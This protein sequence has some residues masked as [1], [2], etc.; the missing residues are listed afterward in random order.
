MRFRLYQSYVHSQVFERIHRHGRGSEDMCG[1]STDWGL[2][3]MQQE[4]AHR[5]RHHT[6]P[7]HTTPHHTSL[8]TQP[9]PT[10]RNATH[11]HDMRHDVGD[12]RHDI[13]D[14]R[15]VI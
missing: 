7:H 2:L 4:Y 14:M 9:N 13:G 8:T 11:G 1:W 5:H 12:M 10:Q 15:H 6:T 3:R